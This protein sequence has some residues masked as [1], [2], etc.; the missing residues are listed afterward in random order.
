MRPKRPIEER[1]WEKVDKRGPDEC[2]PWTA[3]RSG[4]YLYGRLGRDGRVTRAHR[5]AYELAVGPIPEGM[6]VM[7]I[8]D[9]PPCCNPAHLGLGT[10]LENH[11]QKAERGRGGRRGTRAG[12]Y[13]KEEAIALYLEGYSTTQIAVRFGVTSNAVQARLKRAGVQMRPPGPPHRRSDHV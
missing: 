1:F 12:L 13:P 11:R 7:H 6:Q 2:W 4:Q 8:C 9:N 10:N 3:A 5:V